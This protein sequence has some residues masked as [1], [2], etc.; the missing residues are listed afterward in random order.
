MSVAKAIGGSL[1]SGVSSLV[2]GERT[3]AAA[4]DNANAQMDFQERL[5]S[6]AHQREV[7]DLKA[8]G[9]NPILSA[10]GSGS[11]TPSGVSAPIIDSFSHASNAAIS[12]FSALQTARQ[13]E[14]AIDTA[15]SQQRLNNAL[16]DKA[17]AE[18]SS[19]KEDI[20]LKQTGVFGRAVGSDVASSVQDAVHS[21]APVLSKAVTPLLHSARD[22][23][24]DK[25]N[26]II[27]GLRQ[28][29]AK[30]VSTAST[31]LRDHDLWPPGSRSHSVPPSAGIYIPGS[32]PK[33]K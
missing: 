4:Q 13:S 15:Q 26:S 6:T 17:A 24:P 31:W 27:A 30:A 2:G 25:L 23:L 3:N 29:S 33:L 14:A 12:N 16:A 28:S 7:A 32:A 10:G 9:L 5:S 19:V 11:S 22:E 20:R 1:I 8:A 18:S 21:I